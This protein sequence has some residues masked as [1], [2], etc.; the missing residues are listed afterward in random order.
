AP[1]G[2]DAGATPAAD[3]FEE[4]EAYDWTVDPGVEAYYCRY[5]TLTEDLFVQDFRPL[6]PQGTHHVALGYQDPGPPDGTYPEGENGCTGTTFGDV[7]T[8]VATVGA[9]TFS[10]P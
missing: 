2:S 6:V 4:L 9:D 7:Y 1:A 5:R 10:L 8:Y 3:G